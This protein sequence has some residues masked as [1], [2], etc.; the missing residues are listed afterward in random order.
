M[1]RA[2]LFLLPLAL[3]ATAAPQ[4]SKSGTKPAPKPTVSAPKPTAKS[5]KSV[6]KVAPKPTP[7]PLTPVVDPKALQ[8]VLAQAG[9][10]AP[11]TESG[12]TSAMVEAVA[13]GKGRIDYGQGVARAVG[14]GALPPPTLTRSRAQDTL[15]ARDAALADAL[16]QG[17][18]VTIP[19]NHMS[20]VAKPELGEAILAYLMR[21]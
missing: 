19:G 5:G 3:S 11:V 18:L 7:K 12:L 17:Q 2:T 14:L 20:A 4:R 10:P 8:Q 9:A 13:A 15:T 1:S 21:P 6:G 16:P